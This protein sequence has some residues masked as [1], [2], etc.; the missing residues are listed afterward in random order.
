[1][2]ESIDGPFPEELFAS[3]PP[4]LR[5]WWRRAWV[6]DAGARLAMKKLTERLQAVVRAGGDPATD[7]EMA[8]LQVQAFEA[9]KRY[10]VRT[11]DRMPP[12]SA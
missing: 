1:M 10:A 2:S 7:A 6:R 3:T 9:A 12:S 8:T 5:D 4:A 11:K